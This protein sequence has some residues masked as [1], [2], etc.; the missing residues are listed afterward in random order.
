MLGDQ[1]TVGGLYNIQSGA[2]WKML[3][4]IS[5]WRWY[6]LLEI[7]L[8]AVIFLISVSIL[9]VYYRKSGVAIPLPRRITLRGILSTPYVLWQISPLFTILNLGVLVAV[10]G[11]RAIL[12]Y[13]KLFPL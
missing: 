2:T 5:A 6:H 9:H 13:D 8:I 11:V 1:S 10:V 4:K 12:G 7:W 3:L